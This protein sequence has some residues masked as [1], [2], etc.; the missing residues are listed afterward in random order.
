M[1]IQ[2]IKCDACGTQKTVKDFV[3]FSFECQISGNAF[4][5]EKEYDAE[6]CQDCR[7]KLIRAI[8]DIFYPGIMR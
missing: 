1:R 4:I 8:D 7:N 3:E 2:Y 6:I 5:D